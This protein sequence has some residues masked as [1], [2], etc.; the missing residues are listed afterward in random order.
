MIIT[1]SEGG[2]SRRDHVP[3]REQFLQLN[4][5]PTSRQRASLNS[6]DQRVHVVA[7]RST[8]VRTYR[9]KQG[10]REKEREKESRK[11]FTAFATKSRDE[12]MLRRFRYQREKSRNEKRRTNVYSDRSAPMNLPPRRATTSDEDDEIGND[13]PLA[14]GII[15]SRAATS[16]RY[17]GNLIFRGKSE[18]HRLV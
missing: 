5:W 6:L 15:S 12:T 7:I 11:L 9:E 1:L 10:G 8:Y 18:N 17:C 4:T 13:V 16:R 3:L 2:A 14:P